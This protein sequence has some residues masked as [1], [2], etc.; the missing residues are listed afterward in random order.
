MTAT[1]RIPA[2]AAFVVPDAHHDFE[3]W[4]ASAAWFKTAARPQPVQAIRV[5]DEI[6]Y[7]SPQGPIALGRG[8]YLVKDV[9]GRVS[10]VAA[11]QFMASYL[12]CFSDGHVICGLNLSAYEQAKALH[13]Q[14][15]VMCSR[16]QEKLDTTVAESMLSLMSLSNRRRKEERDSER[17]VEMVNELNAHSRDVKSLG[18][19]AR[20]AV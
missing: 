1:Y 19:R 8:G 14:A 15:Q 18:M 5:E 2:P 16:A 20:R 17:L 11:D 6:V 7:T 9:T 12:R 10:C 4:C 3:K 13:Q